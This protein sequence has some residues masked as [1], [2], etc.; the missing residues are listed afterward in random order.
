MA[1]EGGAAGTSGDPV[2]TISRHVSSRGE[3]MSLSL[4]AA[5]RVT[6]G[7]ERHVHAYL[8]HQFGDA[9]APPLILNARARQFSSFMLLLGRIGPSAGSFEPKHAVILKDK[10]EMRI[11]L[12]LA[13]LP[14]PKAFRDAI[15]SLSP[16]QQ[17][18]ARA[19]RS[20][21]LEGSVFGVLLLQL[22]PQLEKVPSLTPAPGRAGG[23]FSHPHPGS[24]AD[25]GRHAVVRLRTRVCRCSTCRPSLLPRRLL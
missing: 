1:I 19:V 5:T 7:G 14:T 20:M 10:D 12:E 23:P 4:N 8:A 24:R 9:E 2:R 6:F 13:K 16:E 17:R 15:S 25:T 18:F 22:K 3:P 21:Q 11:P